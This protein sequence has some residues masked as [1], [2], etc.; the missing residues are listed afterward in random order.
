[1]IGTIS[2]VKPAAANHYYKYAHCKNEKDLKAVNERFS[3]DCDENG[4][5]DHSLHDFVRSERNS[6]KYSWY[7]D[8]VGVFQNNTKVKKI[9]IDAPNCISFSNFFTYCPNLEEIEFKNVDNDK[10]QYLSFAF[11]GSPAI[12]SLSGNFN[13]NPDV[14]KDSWG[15]FRGGCSGLIFNNNYVFPYFEWLDKLKIDASQTIDVSENKGGMGNKDKISL[16]E[17]YTFSDIKAF[18]MADGSWSNGSAITMDKLPTN[19]SFKNAK[20]IEFEG[21]LGNEFHAANPLEKCT[22]I[23]LDGN[24]N[25]RHL[26][27]DSPSFSWPAMK[28]VE[29]GG[30]GYS[31]MYS[32]ALSGESVIKLSNAL[33]TWTDGKDKNTISIMMHNDNFY[34]PEVNIALK[35][36]D[37]DFITPIEQIGGTLPEEV[38]ED[39]G[40]KI[41]GL[42]A[43]NAWGPI[44][45]FD[46]YLQEEILDEIDYSIELPDGYQRCKWLKSTGTKKQY[47]DTG[48]TA[49]NETGLMMIC[50]TCSGD[51][52]NGSFGNTYSGTGSIFCPYAG[53]ERGW[54]GRWN[55]AILSGMTQGW[56][57]GRTNIGKLNWLNDRNWSCTVGMEY[58][59]SGTISEMTSFSTKTIWMFGVNYNANTYYTGCIYRA[60]MSQGTEII[61]D[62]IP[63]LNPDGKPCMYDVINGVEYHNQGAGEDFEYEIAPVIENPYK[64]F[65]LVEGGSYIPDASKFNEEVLQNNELKIVRVEN[66]KAYIE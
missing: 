16:D 39:K 28:T 57:G 53:Q 10:I 64:D 21:C 20:T 52:T 43:I 8:S 26:Y 34:N 29:C 47:I 22:K 31:T 66:Q 36:L 33:P 17:R 38:T 30:R 4:V 1:M 14:V 60:K 11:A 54:N 51:T 65:E 41:K 56:Y 59:Q 2:K 23:V 35:R 18:R 12:K 58:T 63:C 15:I 25:L 50:K 44:S 13:P 61:R 24:S 55:N 27:K 49:D 19:I 9:C 45:L 40:W 32:C 62:F 6:E 46:E 48:L 7:W 42:T 5:W 3:D 37:K